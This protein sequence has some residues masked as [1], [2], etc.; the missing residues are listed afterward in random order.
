MATKK[1]SRKTSLPIKTVVKGIRRVVQDTK[2][3]ARKIKKLAKSKAPGSGAK[4]VKQINRF[5]GATEVL[6]RESKLK[7]LGG[8]VVP[9]K[10]KRLRKKK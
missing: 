8:T 5:F 3:S 4:G 9:R 7:R 10:R 2:D 6:E 1:K